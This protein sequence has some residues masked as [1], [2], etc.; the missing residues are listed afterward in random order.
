MWQVATFQP[1]GLF[2]LRPYNATTSG[3]KTLL[4]PSPFAVKMALL[5]VIFREEGRSAAE[6]EWNALRS[7]EIAIRLPQRLVVNHTF[8]KILRLKK[9]GASDS[10]GTG[11]VTPLGNTIAFRE[12]VGFGGP[13]EVALGGEGAAS[14]A[15]RLARVNYLGKRGGFLQIVAPP[16]PS[17][18]LEAVDGRGW[19]T[20]TAEAGEIVM[21][22]TLQPLDDCGPKM[23]LAHADIYSSKRLTVNRDEG[24]VIRPIVLPVRAISSGRS[25]TL[26]EHL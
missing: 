1:V 18:T 4:V 3:G 8:V 19:T 25:F 10:S 23:T 6:Q 13:I 26:Y 16:R 22:G 7:L 24:R 5:D 21:G 11:L 17:A 2:S 15:L 14:L 9:G 20:L 12:Y